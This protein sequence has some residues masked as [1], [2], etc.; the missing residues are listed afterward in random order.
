MRKTLK[1]ALL[2]S[3]AFMGLLFVLNL[4]LR[5]VFIFYFKDY[6]AVLMANH[7]F[8]VGDKT[9]KDAYLKSEKNTAAKDAIIGPNDRK[10]NKRI[11]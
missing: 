3:L 6:D 10:P 1:A 2:Q 9:I 11:C 7:R 5:A 8:I 4:S